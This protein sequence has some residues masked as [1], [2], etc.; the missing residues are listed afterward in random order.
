MLNDTKKNET[1]T[2]W[3][4]V[5]ELFHTCMPVANVTDM[6]NLIAHLENGYLYMA[7]TDYPYE[8]SFLQPMPAWPVTAACEAFKDVAPPTEEEKNDNIRDDPAG[9]TDR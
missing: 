8:S 7:M 4:A 9:L 5:S 2:L 6:D 1:Q 3:P